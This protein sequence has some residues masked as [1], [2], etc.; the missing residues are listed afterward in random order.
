MPLRTAE[1][2]DSP[3]W[4]CDFASVW[5]CT[6]GAVAPGSQAEALNLPLRLPTAG[7]ADADAW[8]SAMDAWASVRSASYSA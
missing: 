3:G 5:K 1:P 6:Y 8:L 4:Q 2:G 7:A